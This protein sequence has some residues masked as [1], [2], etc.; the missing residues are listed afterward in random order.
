[1]RSFAGH[2]KEAV[3]KLSLKVFGEPLDPSFHPPAKYTGELLG[4]QYLYAQTGKVLKPPQLDPDTIEEEEDDDQV[5]EAEDDNDDEG[6]V[7]ADDQTL[8]PLVPVASR[9]ASPASPSPPPHDRQESPMSTSRSPSPTADQQGPS[10][11][12]EETVGPSGIPGYDK[13]QKLAEYL[14]NLRHRS[15]LSETKVDQIIGL[16]NDL[17]DFDKGRVNYPARHRTKL[18]VGRFAAPRQT[19]VPG[20]DSVKRYVYL[21]AFP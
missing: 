14:V 13:V 16:W 1:M 4:V 15:A 9:P 7:E 21:N 5:Q 12:D 18:N 2:T 20:A 8:A 19:T 11:S 3:N 17:P 6:F 10:S